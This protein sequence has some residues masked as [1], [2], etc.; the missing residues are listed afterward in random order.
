M[1]Y[2]VFVGASGA[3]IFSN[4]PDPTLELLLSTSQ[5]YF[6][7]NFNESVLHVQSKNKMRLVFQQVRKQCHLK[8]F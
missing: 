7:E 3:R 2:F 4:Y 6:S 5:C 8:L 1:K